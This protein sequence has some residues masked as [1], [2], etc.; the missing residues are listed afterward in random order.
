MGLWPLCDSGLLGA[1]AG[2]R[3]VGHVPSTV[4]PRCRLDCVLR[5]PKDTGGGWFIHATIN[6]AHD[7]VRVSCGL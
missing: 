7:I 5:P 6:A 4:A 1:A 2:G 3:G